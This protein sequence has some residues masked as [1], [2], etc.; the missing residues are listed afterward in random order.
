MSRAAAGEAPR[1]LITRRA[2]TARSRRGPARGRAPCRPRERRGG[3]DDRAR[4]GRARRAAHVTPSRRAGG[5]AG[6][7][8]GGRQTPLHYARAHGAELR[9][10]MPDGARRPAS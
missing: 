8:H 3:V 1:G 4:S 7:R 2:Y 9:A 6:W 5:P 10:A